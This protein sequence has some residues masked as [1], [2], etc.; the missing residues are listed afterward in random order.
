MKTLKTAL[1][2]T[3]MLAMAA[4]AFAQYQPTQQY[5]RDMRNYQQDQADYQVTRAEYDR[6]R[7]EYDAKRDR[8]ERDR[9]RY[10][11]RYGYGAYARSYGAAPTWDSERYD[12]NGYGRDTSYSGSSYADP[13]RSASTN[14]SQVAGGLIGAL[15][16]A[17]IGSNVAARNARTE[18]AVLGAVVG[19]F[20][21]S[22]IGKQSAKAKCD[23][24]GY[25]Y[26]YAETM[27]Y[28]E[29]R[30]DRGQ[31]TGQYDYAYY[32]RSRCRLATAPVDN[33]G[34]DVRYVR[35]CPDSRGR[36]RITG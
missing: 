22:Q 30:Y 14:N 32:N 25:Y 20:A 9:A 36:Y 17:A 11:A 8:Y 1:V 3:A 33:Y 2:A 16:G 13:C 24:A 34:D 23:Q 18:G 7:A 4:P 21:G 6:A 27:P 19:G 10:D 15:A 28:R 12:A 31:R 26:N 29:S 35:V 5:Q